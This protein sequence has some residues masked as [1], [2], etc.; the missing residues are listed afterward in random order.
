[1]KGLRVDLGAK[2]MAWILLVALTFGGT[3]AAQQAGWSMRYYSAE[4]WQDTGTFSMLKSEYLNELWYAVELG[5]MLEYDTLSYVDRMQ[6]TQ[7]RAASVAKLDRESTNFRYQ[8]LSADGKQILDTNL[9]EGESLDL[10]VQQ[11]GYSSRSLQA[12]PKE[13][14][15]GTD[16]QDQSV[17]DTQAAAEPE[18]DWV[19]LVV[20]C[21]VASQELEVVDEFHQLY[22]DFHAASGDGAT[23]MA[24][25]AAA[26]LGGGM[27][28]FFYLLWSAGYRKGEEGPTPSWQE[29]I[30]LELYLLVMGGVLFAS[31]LGVIGIYQWLLYGD[32]LMLESG[33][34]PHLLFLCVAGIVAVASGITTITMRTILVRMRC[35]CLLQS[36]WICR[37]IAWS[38]MRMREIIVLIP[39]IWRVALTMVCYLVLRFFVGPVGPMGELYPIPTFLVDLTAFL[40]VCRWAAAFRRVREGSETIAAGN[41]NYRIDTERMPHDLRRQAEAMNN[42]SLGLRSAVE[43][44][45]KSERFKAELIT[46]VSHDLKTPLTSIINYVDLLRST[47]Q[48]DPRAVE[49][50]QVLE[51]KSQRLKKLTE[52]LV[53]ASKA[54]TGTLVVEREKLGMGQLI[55]QAMG[56]YEEKLRSRGLTIV[57]TLPEG[58][59]WVYADGRHLWRVIDNLL[60]NC[61]KYAME[62]TRIYLEL[63]RGKGQV[64][65]TVKNISSQPLNVPAE[66]LMERFVRGDDARTTEGS[67]LGLSIARSLTELQGGTFEIG[68]DGDLFKAT[69]TLPQSV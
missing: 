51:R 48:T 10:L 22:R 50:I 17:S 55:D 32:W 24:L 31:L 44:Q 61:V 23:G 64:V 26:L 69:V 46:N 7:S 39:F 58:E 27:M 41:L 65:L 60:S 11:V 19:E 2:A 15:M 6:V 37:A 57:T 14:G 34:M 68:V 56:E 25:L 33:E 42:I 54:S 40:L 35:R 12:Y 29:G 59:S 43:E 47:E 28:S 1:M 62:G 16:T 63:K 30:G 13:M 8:V 18:P 38:C 5:R 66:R 52:D 9:E 20:R 36:I 21:G 49:Y 45:M 67:G 53:E 4:D 3:W